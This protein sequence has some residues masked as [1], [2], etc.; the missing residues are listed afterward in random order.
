MVKP[1]PKYLLLKSLSKCL[2]PQLHVCS[3]LFYSV[4]SRSGVV[5]DGHDLVLRK[6]TSNLYRAL[7]RRASLRW[8]CSFIAR[9]RP[10][11]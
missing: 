3:V 6:Q 7:W 9:A 11:F 1:V 10:A 8:S 4:Q 5:E 2:R